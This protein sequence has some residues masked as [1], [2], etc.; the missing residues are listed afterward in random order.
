MTGTVL[1]KY[2]LAVLGTALPSLVPPTREAGGD[3]RV[4]SNAAEKSCCQP[5]ASPAGQK[6]SILPAWV[7]LHSSCGTGEVAIAGTIAFASAGQEGH[8][9]AGC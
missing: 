7:G 4:Q 5:V 2:R 6:K 8:R 9:L 1:Q 3:R